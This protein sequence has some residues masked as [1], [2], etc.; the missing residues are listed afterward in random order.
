MTC[1][2]CEPDKTRD[3]IFDIAMG[4]A[5]LLETQLCPKHERELWEKVRRDQ[6]W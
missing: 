1:I 2:G 4:K 5:S 3:V 6:G